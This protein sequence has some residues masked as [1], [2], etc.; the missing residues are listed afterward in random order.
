MQTT[1][2]VALDLPEHIVGIKG[3]GYLLCNVVAA[4]HS[5]VAFTLT[6]PHRS[7]CR[8]VS[9]LRELAVQ[10]MAF[11]L[12]QYGIFLSTLAFRLKTLINHKDHLG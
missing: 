10:E 12:A 6:S 3:K 5:T 11:P 2:L 4:Y 9:S 1:T 8:Q 7:L